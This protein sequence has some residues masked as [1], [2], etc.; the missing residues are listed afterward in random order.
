MKQSFL[1][2]DWSSLQ[3]AAHKIIPSFTIMGISTDFES[4]ARRVQEYSC[5]QLKTDEIYDL[6]LKIENVCTQAC[7]ELKEDYDRLKKLQNEQR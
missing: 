3:T 1:D 7:K 6:V 4:M 2:K 5:T